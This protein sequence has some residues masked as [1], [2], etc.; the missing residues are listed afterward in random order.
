MGY[1]PFLRLRFLVG[2][3]HMHIV[4]MA[5]IRHRCAANYIPRHTVYI[6]VAAALCHLTPLVAIKKKTKTRLL[7]LLI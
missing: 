5:V 4:M 6:V 7:L 2:S 1:L 3:N